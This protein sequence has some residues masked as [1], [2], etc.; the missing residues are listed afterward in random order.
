M[1]V[2]LIGGLPRPSGGVSV[3]L[4]RLVN[5]LGE[6]VE[7]DVLDVQDKGEKE[8]TLATRIRIAPSNRLIKHLWVFLMV[9]ISRCQIVHFNYSSVLSLAAIALVPK[10]KKR[11]VITLHNGKQWDR[12]LQIPKIMKWLIKIGVDRADIIFCLCRD[13]EILFDYLKIDKD[14]IIFLKPQIPPVLLKTD[15]VDQAHTE[16]ADRYKTIVVSSGHVSR[17]YRFEY[18]IRYVNE[19]VDTAAVFFFYGEYMDTDYLAELRALVVSKEKVIF[20]F[21]QSEQ[22]FLAALAKSQAYLRPTDVDSWGIAVADAVLLNVPVIAS[23]VCERFPGTIL[24]EPNNYEQFAKYVEQS[25]TGAKEQTRDQHCYD[26]SSIVY[27]AY[28]KALT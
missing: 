27:N 12:Y 6:D 15:F 22:T 26:A 11:Y 1:R 21:H 14:K 16:M 13:Q 5:A 24:C 20:Y 3:F 18:T 25:Q 2:L 10:F 19:H 4:G 23:T 9:I 17:S 28:L 7:F 8:S